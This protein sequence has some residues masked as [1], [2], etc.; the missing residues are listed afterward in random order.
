ML[1]IESKIL[2]INKEEIIDKLEKMNYIEKKERKLISL[3]YDTKEDS[4]VK[5]GGIVRLRF[6]G[7][8]G[9]LTIKTPIENSS[10]GGIKIFHEN[11]K[12]I[13]FKEKEKEFRK[14]HILLLKTEKYRITYRFENCIVEI[15]EYLGNMNYIPIFLEIEAENE[16]IIIKKAK[17][18]GFNKEKLY[19]G[20][21][22]D[23]INKYSISI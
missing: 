16:K 13:N 22:L 2:E 15:D 17:E 5:K 12:E 11:E 14:T 23:L 8:K 19:R 21:T 3:L 4:I 6:D 20:S 18:L 9:Y 10:K 1:E 7:Q